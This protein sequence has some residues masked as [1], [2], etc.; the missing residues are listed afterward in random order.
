MTKRRIGFLATMA[1]AVG[2][3]GFWVTGCSLD[4][5][6]PVGQDP[7]TLD[8]DPPVTNIAPADHADLARALGVT[9]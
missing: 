5:A 4:P 1:L 8:R 9:V 7:D 3:L 2:S 6:G